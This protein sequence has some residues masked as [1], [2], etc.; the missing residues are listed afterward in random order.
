LRGK[1][2]KGRGFGFPILAHLFCHGDNLAAKRNVCKYFFARR[3]ASGE[4]ARSRVARSEEPEWV[5]ERMARGIE[6]PDVGFPQGN[7][8]SGRCAEL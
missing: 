8:A 5:S 2:Q 7:R 3:R 6:G 1:G 4:S